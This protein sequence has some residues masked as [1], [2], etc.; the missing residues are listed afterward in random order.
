MT[1]PRLTSFKI[2]AVT[3]A[4]DPALRSPLAQGRASGPV[5]VQPPRPVSH[6]PDHCYRVNT[7]TWMTLSINP[8]ILMFTPIT[9]LWFTENQSQHKGT[10]RN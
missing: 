3:A 7:T 5:P 8:S 1:T 9:D 4:P 6:T 10:R 2:P